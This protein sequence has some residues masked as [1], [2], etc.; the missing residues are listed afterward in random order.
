MRDGNH[1]IFIGVEVLGIQ[2]FRSIYDL[3]A[4]LIAILV[5]DLTALLLYQL[6]THIDVTEEEI[7]VVD[8]L[9]ELIVL[10]LQLVNIELR[11]LS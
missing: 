11:E 4:T 9:L 8:T 10:M 5:D 7:Q 6:H 2:V 1:H 3:R